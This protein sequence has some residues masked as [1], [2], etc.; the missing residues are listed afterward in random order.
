MNE[1]YLGMI[2]L[3][4]GNFAP[5]GYAMCDGALLAIAS[6]TALYSIIGTT[7]GGDGTSNFALPKLIA[8]EGTSY[9]IAVQG[10]FPQ[11]S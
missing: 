4:A 5:R 7:Y 10:M 1:P 8:P 11:R 9:V 3:F 2:F 6:N